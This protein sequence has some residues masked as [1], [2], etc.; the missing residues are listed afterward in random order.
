[1]DPNPFAPPRTTDLDVAEAPAGDLTLD[2]EATAALVAGGPW[3]RL[4]AGLA[5]VWAVVH[6]V[7]L[8][9]GRSGSNPLWLTTSALA[10]LL[11]GVPAWLVGRCGRATRRLADG[12]PGAAEQALRTQA[13]LFSVLGI[14]C[15]LFLAFVCVVV[16]SNQLIQRGLLR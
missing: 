10:V 6:W 11:L 5:L 13:Q 14:G 3:A 4:T 1:V 12:E 15:V 8:A 9:L 7:L 16:A 2:P